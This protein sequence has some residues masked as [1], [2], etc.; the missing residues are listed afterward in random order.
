MLIIGGWKGD[1]FPGDGIL[2]PTTLAK[3]TMWRSRNLLALNGEA[4]QQLTNLKGL[5]IDDCPQLQC[6]P[7]QGLPASLSD[8]R[9]EGCHPLL[10]QR[11]EK[12]KG[13]DW[14]KIAHIP[15]I[16]IQS[17]SESESD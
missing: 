14:H 15:E 8:L 5:W 16:K 7:E 3:I 17:T 6:L 12:D 4:F 1:S 13:Q 10:K 9:I 11:C 2:L